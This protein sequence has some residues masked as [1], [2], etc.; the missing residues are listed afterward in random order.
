MEVN[1]ELKPTR[2]EI[3]LK[4]TN[5]SCNREKIASRGIITGV[6][7]CGDF[8]SPKKEGEK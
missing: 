4:C 1:N 6:C 8:M 2:D 5:R 7:L 3:V